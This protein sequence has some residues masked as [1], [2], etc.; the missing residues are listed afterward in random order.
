MDE[1]VVYIGPEIFEKGQ[2]Y[3]ALSRVKTLNGLH[4][5]S[6]CVSKIQADPKVISEYLRLQIS[7]A[8]SS[9]NTLI[10][11]KVLVFL[12]WLIAW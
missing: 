10:Y 9:Y 7:G 6:L 4:L 12:M 11:C 8:N 3:V 5:L 1:A 2:A